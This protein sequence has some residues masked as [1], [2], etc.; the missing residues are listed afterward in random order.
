MTER[1]SISLWIDQLKAGDVDAA[2][3]LWERFYCRL[4]GLVRR[5]LGDVPQRASDEEEVLAERIQQF[6]QRAQPSLFP[7]LGDRDDLWRLL[8]AELAS[9][10]EFSA[11]KNAPAYSSEQALGSMKAFQN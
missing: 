9:A 3:P 7:K 10:K 1:G 6:F 4:L 5:K 11:N 2:Q 8:V